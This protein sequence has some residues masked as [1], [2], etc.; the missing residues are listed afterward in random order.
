M[1][2]TNPHLQMNWTEIRKFSYVSIALLTLS[3]LPMQAQ[4]S[5][6]QLKQAAQ[7]LSPQQLNQI[8]N[9]PRARQ[10]AIQQAKA[11]GATDEQIAEGLDK[12]NGQ[13][14]AGSRNQNQRGNAQR[15]MRNDSTD[16]ALQQD[17]MYADSLSLATKQAQPI[18]DKNT[19]FGREIF[20]N[21][22]L[23]FAPNLNIATPKG[24]R[25][26]A[27]D[28]LIVNIWGA[29][30][31]YDSYTVTP[32]GAILIQDL[33][34]VYVAGMSVEQAQEHVKQELG[35]MYQDLVSEMPSTYMSLT[36]GGI[37]SI[38]VNIAGEVATPGTYT[39]P[40]LATLF[41]ALY[42]AGGVSDI[43]S[44]REIKVYRNSKLIG[45]LD[46]YDYLL[47]GKYDTN[48][49]LEDND[50]I[51]VE[52]YKRLVSTEG[53]LKRERIYEMTDGETL[54]DLVRFAGDFKG[55]AYTNNIT[56]KRKNGRMHSIYNVDR[57]DFASFPMQDG[58][59]VKVDSVLNRFSNRITIEGAV[60]RPGEYALGGNVNTLKELIEKAEG[61]KPDAFKNRAILTR[62]N[63][64]DTEE[65]ITID[66]GALMQGKAKDIPLKRED[67][68]TISSIYDTRESYN[69][70]VQGAVNKPDTLPFRDNLTIEDV[71]L[72]S[73]GLKEAASL[74]KVE[75]SR[76]IKDPKAMAESS[77]IAETFNLD[78]TDGLHVR[79][80]ENFT[81]QPF[82][83]VN[84]RFS[85]AYQEQESVTVD[86]EVLFKG[87]YVM[88]KK[89]E[90]LSDLINKAGGLTHDAYI[91][92]ASLKRKMSDAE[93]ARVETLLRISQNSMSKK[94]SISVESLN[95]DNYMVGI[96]LVSAM[97]KPGGEADIT[98]R[99][100]DILTI[101][102]YQGTVKISGA[103]VYPNTVA[104]KK[105]MDVGEYLDQAGGYNDMSRKRPIVIY[106]NGTVAT[107]KKKL[108][109]KFYPKVEPGAEILIPAKSAS[110]KGVGLAE[111]MSVASSTTSIAAMVTSIINNMK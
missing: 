98:L 21:K 25:I 20:S 16:P 90:R 36:L 95:L 73:G 48:I 91:K 35:R 54:A 97:K 43:G 28:E 56:V 53:K 19:V 58:D 102:Q 9:D 71:I 27:G 64:D 111:V 15:G 94:D 51:V 3:I 23:T 39:L 37:R 47:N 101:P 89:N 45:K 34:P 11:A 105:G 24:Y 107:T 33:G 77:R 69:V 26:A 80:N 59:A 40:S 100:G 68:L 29:S 70:I 65:V 17:S 12:L 99:E 13:G 87:Q 32:E 44:L 78:I 22:N 110:N 31:N 60:Y 74:V 66:L 7:G 46:V 1:K 88:S 92:G 6:N 96:D 62:L 14:A 109:W 50:M 38:K 5:N 79:G 2:L 76:R 61:L 84:V 57:A 85:P 30:Q 41:N 106:A 103:V 86:G 75:V 104:Y 52:P 63:P 8:K 42:M 4:M 83:V 67:I 93:K 82:D 81:L 108:F 49:R 18:W 10:Q 72:Q 55:D